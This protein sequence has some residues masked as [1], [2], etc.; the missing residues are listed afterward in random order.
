MA[1]IVEKKIENTVPVLT[2]IPVE[3]KIPTDF[4]VSFLEYSEG[5]DNYLAR[6][7]KVYANIDNFLIEKPKSEWNNL[8]LQLQTKPI[9]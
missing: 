5:L 3:V 4:P 2:P 1:K 9:V 6:A 8:V 7:L